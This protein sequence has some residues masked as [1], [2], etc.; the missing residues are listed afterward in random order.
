[1][2]VPRCWAF[3]IGTTAWMQA[4]VPITFTANTSSHSVT[5]SSSSGRRCSV[6]KSAAL[7]TSTSIRPNVD[8]VA[9]ASR[10][11]SSG[12]RTSVR[13]NKARGLAAVSASTSRPGGVTSASTTAA[14]SRA[15]RPA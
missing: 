2:M 10:R 14:P 1:M 3:M 8:T 11:E 12:Q 15:K 4:N 5:D 6:V 13:T 9:S 7:L